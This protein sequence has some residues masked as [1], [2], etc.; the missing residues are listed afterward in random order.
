MFLG[1]ALM[2]HHAGP[3]T[4]GELAGVARRDQA[5]R[6]GR[7][8]AADGLDRGAFARAFV[9]AHGDLTRN[10]AQR[11]VGNARG[12]GDGGDLGVKVARSLRGAS[13]LLAGR[14]VGV[15]HIAAD[16]VALGNHLCGLQHVPVDLGL[17][18]GQRWVLE[19]VQ[20]HFLLHA[21][22]AFHAAR[23]KHIALTRDDAL[24]GHGNGLQAR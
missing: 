17:L 4:V 16:A 14:A 8:Q 2:H 12:N 7:A 3:C 22:D 6:Q 19:H 21:R 5:A 24:R 1:H 13:L 15:H 23:H 18:A 20:V 10:Q 11:F 9:T